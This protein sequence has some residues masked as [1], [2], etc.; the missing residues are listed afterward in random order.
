MVFYHQ[1]KA[2]ILIRET[3]GE[4]EAHSKCSAGIRRKS[5]LCIL[6]IP[7]IFDTIKEKLIRGKSMNFQEFL[8]GKAFD[9]YKYFG[10]HLLKKGA[11]FRL[12]TQCSEGG[13]AGRFQRM[14]TAGDE[15]EGESR[16]V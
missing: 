12:C 4:P 15:T 10:A 13:A 1:R 2:Q 7:I 8:Q 9:A 16:G 6:Y 14:G 3:G 11:I 5:C